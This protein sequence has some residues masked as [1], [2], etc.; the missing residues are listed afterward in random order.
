[1]SQQ[2]DGI[3]DRMRAALPAAMKARDTA[4]VSVLRSALAAIENA[5]AVELPEAPS[6]IIGDGAIAGAAVGLGA[7]EVARRNLTE[8]QVAD[9]VRTEIAD[10]RHAA[11][12]YERV[13]RDDNARKLRDEASV[14]ADYLDG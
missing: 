13:G 11:T 7:T 14:L 8:T 10:R 1:M 9:I 4:T 2:S 5:E 3:R 12:G 6:P